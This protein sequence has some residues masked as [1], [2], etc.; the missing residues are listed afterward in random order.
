M[1]AVTVVATQTQ[2][3]PAD[4]Q[5]ERRMGTAPRATER[6]ADRG[7]IETPGRDG[8]EVRGVLPAR[9]AA[10]ER[11]G[12]AGPHG[13]G[14]KELAQ[15]LAEEARRRGFEQIA[16]LAESADDADVLVDVETALDDAIDAAHTAAVVEARVEAAA[17]VV[18]GTG[19]TP[20]PDDVG[21]RRVSA[22]GDTMRSHVRVESGGTAVVE[23]VV[24]ARALEI[25][26]R[27]AGTCNQENRITGA[28]FADMESTEV[29]LVE[30]P[31]VARRGATRLGGLAAGVKASTRSARAREA[32]RQ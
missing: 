19:W 6:A 8:A 3:R 18:L 28:I 11:A 7:I 17:H 22:D 4:A 1:Q 9:D 23:I 32:R 30:A 20:Q 14:V 13:P 5:D 29:E 21:Q 24:D 25:N 15:A 10:P 16:A 2:A 31:V 27:A 12:P 26:G